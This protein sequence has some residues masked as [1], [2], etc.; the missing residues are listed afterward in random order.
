MVQHDVDVP[1]EVFDDS[2]VGDEISDIGAVAPANE[3][4]HVAGVEEGEDAFLSVADD[5][6]FAER[7]HELYTVFASRPDGIVDVT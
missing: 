5:R 4:A 7:D 1:L 3:Y 2:L 6:C